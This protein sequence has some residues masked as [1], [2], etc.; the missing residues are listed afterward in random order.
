MATKTTRRNRQRRGYAVDFHA[1]IVLPE[2]VAF[3]A[4]HGMVREVSQMV[5]SRMLPTIKA[6][7]QGKLPLTKVKNK[8]QAA[9][10]RMVDPALQLKDMDD[11]GVDISVLSASL[12]HQCT[13]HAGADAALGIEKKTNDR[14]AEFIAHAPN[15]FVGLG[16]VPMQS[17]P[18]A[19]AELRRCMTGL[20]LKGVQISSMAGRRELGDSAL[21]RFWQSAESLGAVIFIHPSG[22]LDARFAK[23]Q[24]WNSVGQ[25]LEETMAMSSLIHEG[26]L[27]RFPKLKICMAHGGGYLPFYT[28]RADRN[29]RDKPFTRGPMTMAPSAYLRKFY[30]ESCIYNPDMLEYLAGKVGANRI[31]M[32]SDYP[33]GES[34]PVGFVRRARGISKDAKEKI[35]WRNASRLLG[36]SL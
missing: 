10:I 5:R 16:S 28:G 6:W 29:Y 11:R 31:V 15:R 12:I 8:G 26:V 7:E 32:G 34:D 24:L 36:L 13:Y 1:H 20:G 21:D 35:L 3:A 30:Y 9:A 33:V 23:H 14:M 17:V 2:A 4:R 19:V 18:K 27:D 22:V 25:P